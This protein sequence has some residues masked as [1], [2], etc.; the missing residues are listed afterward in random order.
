MAIEFEDQYLPC[1]QLNS[2][3][4]CQCLAWFNTDSTR[5]RSRHH[6]CRL[7]RAWYAIPAILE[8]GDPF[9][10]FNPDD[11]TLPKVLLADTYQKIL[12]NICS[13]LL[14]NVATSIRCSGRKF[15][16]VTHAS[17]APSVINCFHRFR[18]PMTLHSRRGTLSLMTAISR[19]A[20]ILS[21]NFQTPRQLL[22]LFSLWMTSECSK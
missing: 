14:F 19:S 13:P 9:L 8:V 6:R 18:V 15:M 10:P 3:A 16:W 22:F 5:C 17:G 21:A 1:V 4:N 7:L 11:P 2:K 20:G 12:L